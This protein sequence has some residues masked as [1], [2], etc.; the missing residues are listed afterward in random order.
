MYGHG[1]GFMTGEPELFRGRRD[2]KHI[3]MEWKLQF[4]A[5]A[6]YLGVVAAGFALIP[7]EPPLFG[8]GM[9]PGPMALLGRI[10]LPA[11]AAIGLGLWVFRRSKT[12]KGMNTAA[13][14][15]GS[16]VVW[17]SALVLF[18]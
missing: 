11:V 16:I 15:A 18:H 8:M 4:S 10:G 12:R 1:W 7:R 14:F 17:A 5:W 2:R 13:F 6:S 3:L 9:V